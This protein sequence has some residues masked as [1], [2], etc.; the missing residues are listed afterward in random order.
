MLMGRYVRRER[1][2]NRR[3]DDPV[4][5]SDPRL[6]VDTLVR[7]PEENERSAQMENVYEGAM[8]LLGEPDSVLY[9]EPLSMAQHYDL[10]VAGSHHIGYLP[11]RS[12]RKTAED[13]AALFL[14]KEA[15]C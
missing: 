10:M 9:A 1:Q 13:V 11:E 8:Q 15:S 5:P 6:S 7:S 14:R 4:D 12:F 2:I 3:L